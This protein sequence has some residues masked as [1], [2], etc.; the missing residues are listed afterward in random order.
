ME[1]TYITDLTRFYLALGRYPGSARARLPPLGDRCPHFFRLIDAW[2]VV[3]ALG[4]SR[5]LTVSP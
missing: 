5:N 4:C 2:V 1:F 3:L